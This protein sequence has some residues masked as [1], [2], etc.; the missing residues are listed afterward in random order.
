MALWPIE[1]ILNRILSTDS[2]AASQ[3]AP[4]SGKTLQIITRA[5]H[6]TATLMFEQDQIRFN[7]I[8]SEV[9][10]INPDATISGSTNDLLKLLLSRP[11]DRP[12]AN[13]Q[14]TLSGDASFIQDLY[15]TL[16]SMDIDWEDYLA[17]FLGDVITNEVSQF[18]EDARNWSRE[19]RVSLRRNVDDYLKQEA[20]YFP[21]REQ[22]D[23]FNDELDQL[24]LR[25]DRVKARTD[26]LC[27]RLDRLSN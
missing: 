18:A 3:L 4:F 21:H 20:R 25:I 7:A 17:P 1:Q 14:I 12:L 2:H 27:Q 11:E 19:A 5:P 26:L 10:A 24:K 8:D 16:L 6:I 22:V 9:L 23:K 15:S 13:P